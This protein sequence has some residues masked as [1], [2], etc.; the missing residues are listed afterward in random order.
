[1]GSSGIFCGKYIKSV[2][3]SDELPLPLVNYFYQFYKYF[4]SAYYI[5]GTVLETR[6]SL[7]SWCI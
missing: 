4:L 1:M 2:I 5:L 6:W 7:F 3:H